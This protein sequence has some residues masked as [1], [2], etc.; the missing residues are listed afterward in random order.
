MNKLLTL[1]E[2]LTDPSNRSHSDR[3]P[4]NA[5]SVNNEWDSL[6]EVIVGEIAEA[7]FPDWHRVVEAVV[8]RRHHE[9]FKERVGKR[10]PSQHVA[11]AQRELDHL[12]NFLDRQ[13]VLVR[14]PQKVPLDAPIAT[15]FFKVSGGMYHAMPRDSVLVIG[16]SI[17]EAPMSWRNRHFETMAYRTIFKEYSE[18]GA[19]W[20]CAPKP[21]LADE[22]YL[23]AAGAY[24]LSLAVS[25][26]EPLFD[27]ADFLRLGTT[28]VGQVSH[29][30]NWAGIRW[31]RRTLGPLFDVK[32]FQFN[33][34]APMHIDTTLMPLASGKLLINP[35]WVQQLPE[36][37]W[38]WDVRCAPKPRDDDERP[39][40]LSSAWL[41][42]NVLV[43]DERHVLVEENDVELI[44]LLADWNIEAIPLPFQN[45]QN[46]GG[47]F[48]C[49]TL[50]IRRG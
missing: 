43:L 21:M 17:I 13:G 31:L 45:V 26:L 4:T 16:N 46:F 35:D 38:D 23:S 25:E 20:I 48:H 37:F 44:T 11:A 49:T 19:N 30:T 1:Q 32:I 5:V 28:L 22:S 40:F 3:E 8:P 50:D 18:R 39:L 2:E 34:P 36:I 47:S 33:E 6:R 7:R 42:M 14:R 9:I 24:D 27:A 41:N 15:P 12:A 10:F 29:V